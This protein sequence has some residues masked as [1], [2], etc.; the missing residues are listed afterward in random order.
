MLKLKIGKTAGDLWTRLGDSGSLSCSQLPECMS[1]QNGSAPLAY[2]ALGWL[3]KE[4]KVEFV[5]ENRD[6]KV[7]LNATEVAIYE[8]LKCAAQ[9]EQ[10]G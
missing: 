5:L 10:E 6:L 2:V 7:R 4:D 1:L 9:K 8:N 3:A